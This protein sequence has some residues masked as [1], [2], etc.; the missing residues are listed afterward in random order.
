MKLHNWE[1]LLNAYILAAVSMPFSYN[2]ALGMD[3]CRF[4]FG[5]IHAQTGIAIGTQFASMYST[6]KEALATMRGFCGKPS[7]LLSIEK[8]MREH[9]FREIHPNFA[10]RGDA[11]LVP[12]TTGGEFL[13]IMDLNGRDVL[14]VGDGIRRVPVSIKCRAWRIA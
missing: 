7:L 12:K 4:T 13:G 14:S 2:S 9:G 11:V 6:R 8:L 10:G 1:S 3:C 5:A